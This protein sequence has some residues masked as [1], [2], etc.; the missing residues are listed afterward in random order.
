MIQY[1]RDITDREDLNEVMD[2]LDM[3]CQEYKVT[4]KIISGKWPNLRLP[5]WT[6]E[7]IGKDEQ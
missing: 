7:V 5:C 6:I 1:S 2:A 4:K 3:L